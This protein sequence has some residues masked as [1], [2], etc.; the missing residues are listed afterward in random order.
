MNRRKTKQGFTLIEVLLAMTLLS[1]MIVLLF[2]SLKIC[3]ESWERGEK[4]IAEVNSVA[5]VYN[6]FQRHLSVA[7]P[8]WNDFNPE[9]RLFSFQG[10]RRALQFVSAFPSSAGRSG[11]QLIT[12]TLQKENRE[13][14]IKVTLTPFFPAAEGEEWQIEEETLI[15]GVQDL[16]LAYFGP[17]N[18]ANASRWQQEWL[19]KSALPQ[20]VKI[21]I[22]L[23]NEM[24]WPEMV[25]A[26]RVAAA[27]ELEE[28]GN[29]DAEDENTDDAEENQ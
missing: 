25:I 5:A 8:L 18:G 13:Q 29:D 1:I 26:P 12:L 23:E 28:L 16:S 11:L 22:T 7:R 10:D 17:E 21:K 20:L 6:F 19:Q 27:T 4:K 3:A 15:R 2:G 9:E 14:I 24:F